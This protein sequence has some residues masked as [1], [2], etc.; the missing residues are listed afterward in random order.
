[1]ASER[2]MIQAFKAAIEKDR[3][4]EA[5]RRAFADWLEEHGHDDEA[6]IQRAWT[7]A[8]QR[9]AEEWMARF[10]AGMND[11]Y[12]DDYPEEERG[13]ELDYDG[14]I[15]AANAYLDSGEY[16][17]FGY[18]TPSAAYE[19]GAMETFWQHFQTLT[20]RPVPEE[21]AGHHFFACAC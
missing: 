5:T 16:L 7:P 14:L 15:A 10:V 3:Y 11:P 19:E 12:A 2:E 6:V 13:P 20:G 18:D 21:K 17:Y 4:D 9:E 8:R 1:M